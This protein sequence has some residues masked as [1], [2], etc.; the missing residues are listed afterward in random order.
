[1]R[2]TFF[3]SLLTSALA[4]SLPFVKER[5]RD[6][7]VATF[8]SLSQRQLSEKGVYAHFMFGII[9]S[10]TAADWEKDISL[11]KAVGIDAFALNAGKDD[12][13]DAQLTLAYDAADKLGFKLFISFD[14]AYWTTGDISTI[15]TYLNTYGTRS[16]QLKVGDR[17]FVSTFI[18]D[19]FDWR[20]VEAQSIPLFACPNWQ[21]GSFSTAASDCGFS[22]DAWPTTN[23][24]PINQ[25]KT[26][27]SDVN[28][29][30]SLG[31]KPYMM[32]VSPWFFTHYGPDLYNKN[33]AFLSDFLWQSRWQQILDISPQ[34]VEIITWND[35]GESHYVGPLHPENPS[36]Y[37]PN[38]QENGA[39]KWVEGMDHSAWMDVAAP[40]IKA[41]KAGASSPT[42]DEI[43]Y[44]YHL[45]SK[46]AA[47]SDAVG[48]PTGA[49]FPLDNV[50]ATILASA[51]A[52]VIVNGQRADVQ[53]GITTVV[54]P[55]NVG[56]PTFE[57]QRDGTT[58]FSG[59]G[60][61]EITAERT[62]QPYNAFVGAIK[63]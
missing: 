13:N 42:V 54:G 32:P 19:G 17:A 16:S 26:T 57:F 48:P 50:F 60:G 18:G 47:C 7:T 6:S 37:A 23:N 61:K 51:P 30:N 40:Y 24:Q 4:F 43:V 28:Y 35:F 5:N 2:A 27:A 63:A 33:W 12:H 21:P 46:A 62:V 31:G 8:N 52:T 59:T 20:A 55:L 39:K 49:D 10:Y 41:Y 34:Y 15:A 44:Y 53:A 56:A 25:N 29:I 38:G 22:W 9:S 3:S 45:S 58:L 11:A 36:V 14:F 1:M